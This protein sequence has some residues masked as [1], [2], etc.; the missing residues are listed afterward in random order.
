M[1]WTPPPRGDLE[2]DPADKHKQRASRRLWQPSLAAT[3][4]PLL[5]LLVLLASMGGAKVVRRA[6]QNAFRSLYYSVDPLFLGRD[7]TRFPSP[8]CCQGGQCSKPRTGR[9]AVLTY[10]QGDAYLPLL[11]QLECSLHKSNP[12]LEFG[13]MLVRGQEGPA[14]RKWLDSKGL[15][16]IE[17][18][19]IT[20]PNHFE[21]RYGANFVKLRALSLTQYDA[22]L[23][24]D[25]D[26]VV[27]GD[28]A[29]LFSLPTEFAAV[30][31]Q[32]KFM[33]RWG[34]HL[35]GINGGVLLL[36]PCPAVQQHMMSL[37]E[38]HPRLRFAFGAAEQD[39][40][41]W[42]YHYTGIRLPL[43]YNTM[44]SDSLK[45]N[46]TLGGRSPIIVHFTQNKPFKGAQ[47]GKPGHQFLCTQK[48][49]AGP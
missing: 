35:R 28:L 6:A 39:F 8:S 31:D 43:E 41:H 11:Q 23:L 48:E 26:L 10:L 24:V 5:L 7:D 46:V 38:E 34:P 27:V 37:L 36:R 21:P 3:C 33:G 2:S 25:S 44:A 45:G 20:Y 13:A 47:A 4:A 40:F 29:P 42:Y 14:V 12:E 16:R 22:V 9:V 19:P 49:L 30:W 15:T 1:P 32:P 17:V 18:D